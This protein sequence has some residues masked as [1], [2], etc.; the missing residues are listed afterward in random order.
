[1]TYIFA[2]DLACDVDGDGREEI[3]FLNTNTYSGASDS[4]EIDQLF[5]FN[6][7]TGRFENILGKDYNIGVLKNLAGRSVACVDRKGKY[8]FCIFFKTMILK[9]LIFIIFLSVGNGKY[10]I[11][12][13]NYAALGNDGNMVGAHTILE[14]DER[15][16]YGN[17]IYLKNIGEEVGVKKFTGN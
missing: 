10:G 9:K 2:F 1:M 11:Y 14:M 7:E 5:R 17:E 3:Y 15:R 8:F 6:D 4:G 13:A 16:S 12:L